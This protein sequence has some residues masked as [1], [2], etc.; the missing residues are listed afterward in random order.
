VVFTPAEEA[1]SVNRGLQ[2]LESSEIEKLELRGDIV[3]G[4]FILNTIDE[5]GVVWVITDISGWWTAPPSDVDVIERGFGDGAYEVTGRYTSR[6]LTITGVF[7]TPSP[8][9]VEAARDRLVQA[10]N[11]IRRGAW[12]KTGR[13]PIRASYVY[14]SGDVDIDTVNTRGRTEFSISLRAPDPIKYAWNDEAPDGYEFAEIPVKNSALGYNGQGLVENIGNYEVPCIFEITGPFRGP[15]TLF[16]R[17]T[18]ELILIT[19]SLKG[20]LSRF[21]VNKELNFDVST[22]TDIASLTTTGPHDYSVGD[23]VFISGMGEPFDGDQIITSVPTSTT[24]TFTTSAADVE[25]VSFKTFNEGTATLETTQEHGF[26]VGDSIVVNGVDALFDTVGA[27]ILS[28]PTATTFTY[29]A[30][31]STPQALSS[32]QLTSNIATLS[33][34]Q[35]H[36]FIVG[37]EVVVSGAGVNYDGTF[38]ILGVPTESTFTYAFTRTNSRE[39][40]TKSMTNDVVTLTTSA[41]HGFVEDEPVNVSGVDLS[42]NGGYTIDSTT[43]NTF[44]YRRP[45]FTEIAVTVKAISANE[46]TITTNGA[47]GFAIG[48]KVTIEN[49]DET[50]NGTYAITSLPSNTTFTF[51]KTASDLVSILVSAGRVYA[52]S[53]KV[54]NR[55]IIGNVATLITDSAHGAIFGEEIEVTGMGAPFNGTHTITGIPFLNV[56]NFELE[57]PNIALEQPFVV[58]RVSRTAGAIT[59]LTTA[60][61]HGYSV[62]Q[63]IRVSGIDSSF[64]GT[65]TIT[66]VPSTTK[67]RYSTPGGGELNEADAPNGAEVIKD[68]GFFEMSGVIEPTAVSNGLATVG[69]SLPF[70]AASGS[71]SVSNILSRRPAAGNAIRKN[72]V[73]FTPGLSGAT[74]IVS[75]DILEIDT[76]DHVVAFNGSVDGARGRVDVLADFIKLAP[77][78]NTI[79]FEDAGD[80][81]GEATLRVFY[82]SGWLG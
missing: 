24:F 60:V 2:N 28:V 64:N 61:A 12:L 78:F 73:Q 37:E 18:N 65:Y 34:T 79:E 6:P 68:F 63:V 32:A 75:A 22:L 76:K 35:P 14:L 1:Y 42:L 51:A 69:G 70:A 71:A 39:I 46:A 43:L 47:H 19:Q 30:N 16:N 25:A 17:T 26:S 10:S 80:P 7:L 36:G 15:G 53:R 82:R 9:L 4:D 62:G 11:L 5:Y 33:T 49:V 50:F 74:S 40:A 44:S 59:E 55:E 20:R 38:N 27:T 72:D 57:N 29:A 54:R 8:S 52:A 56:I 48:E 3:L 67:L 77:G 13:S 41:T 58:R 23:S 66:N 45:R 21:I 81:D 31:R